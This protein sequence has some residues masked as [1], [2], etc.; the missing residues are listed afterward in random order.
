VLTLLVRYL[1]LDT[2]TW[3]SHLAKQRK[4]YV[5]LLEEMTI[6]PSQLITPDSVVIAAGNS[7]GAD[8]AAARL[9]RV[10]DHPLHVDK[11]E[12]NWAK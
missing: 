7:D 11:N 2:S 5:S 12:S 6:I 8:G 4:L 1:P 3:E 10:A 9:Q